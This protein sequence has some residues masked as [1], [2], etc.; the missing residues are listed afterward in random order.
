MIERLLEQKSAILVY[1]NEEQAHESDISTE[2]YKLMDNL[3]DVL[4]PAEVATTALSGEKYSTLSVL[5]PL[6]TAMVVQ[7]KQLKLTDSVAKTIRDD[8]VRTIDE[9]FLDTEKSKLA[10]CATLLDPRFKAKCFL[11]TENRLKA[12]QSLLDDL[13]K[14]EPIESSVQTQE[15]SSSDTIQPSTKRPKLVL[16]VAMTHNSPVLS[17]DLNRPRCTMV[18]LFFLSL[19]FL[20]LNNKRFSTPNYL[21]LI[22]SLATDPRYRSS[23]QKPVTSASATH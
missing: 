16:W 22:I 20:Q 18:F 19:P 8:L 23:H 14:L 12:T 3:V 17:L 2:D 11:K 5:I 7:L 21:L 4:E 1:T 10:T 9:Q 15:N 6:L 13:K